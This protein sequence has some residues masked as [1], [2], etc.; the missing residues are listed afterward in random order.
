MLIH[1][2]QPLRRLVAAPSRR[3]R[4]ARPGS[5]LILVVALLVLIALIGTAYISTARIDRY[6]AHQHSA[7]T[8]VDL[9]LDGLINTVQSA[10]TSDL[11]DITTGK[12]RGEPGPNL[13]TSTSSYKTY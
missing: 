10:I 8:Q 1:P 4:L 5:V 13:S 11:F 2:V 12:Y 6:T 7:N 9:L 3:L